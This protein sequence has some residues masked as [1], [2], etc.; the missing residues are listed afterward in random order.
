MSNSRIEEG[1]HPML[2]EY[3]SDT[4]TPNGYRYDLPGS[5]SWDVANSEPA[6][7]MTWE[8]GP[9]DD[10]DDLEISLTLPAYADLVSRA[11]AHCVACEGCT[12]S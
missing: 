12:R 6:T 8:V 9:D 2:I 10:T 3:V 1:R 11:R 5:G 4:G 7:D